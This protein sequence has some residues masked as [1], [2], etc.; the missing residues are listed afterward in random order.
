MVTITLLSIYGHDSF[1]N[2]MSYIHPALEGWTHY[3]AIWYF[4][5]ISGIVY[6]LA[7]IFDGFI[8]AKDKWYA[9]KVFIPFI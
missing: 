9:F 1:F 4:A 3:H 2:D 8:A 7:N 5:S 6:C